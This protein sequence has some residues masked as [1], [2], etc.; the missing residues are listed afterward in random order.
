MQMNRGMG[1][2]I[3]WA[4]WLFLSLLAKNANIF[5]NSRFVQVLTP[6]VSQLSGGVGR[7]GEPMMLSICTHAILL[8]SERPT[9]NAYPCQILF[10]QCR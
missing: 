4:L 2:G 5:W 1:R 3:G 8:G 7:A 9:F 10:V 6:F